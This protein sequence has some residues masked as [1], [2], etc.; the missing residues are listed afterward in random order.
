MM[1]TRKANSAILDG[2]DVAFD[3]TSSKIALTDNKLSKGR[4]TKKSRGKN[5]SRA[6]QRFDDRQ[7]SVIG[8]PPRRPWW[9]CGFAQWFHHSAQFSANT[10]R[11]DEQVLWQDGGGGRRATLRRGGCG[12]HILRTASSRDFLKSQQC[13]TFW[14]KIVV[15]FD[16]ELLILVHSAGKLICAVHS[17]TRMQSETFAWGPYTGL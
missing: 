2:I 16:D 1:T 3:N 5:D 9:R 6:A 17:C 12:K 8:N 15:S 13:T 14:P 4:T 7:R 10:G 11:T